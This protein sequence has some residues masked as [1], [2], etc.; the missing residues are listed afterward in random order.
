MS[1]ASGCFL[2][3]GFLV[4]GGGGGA[5]VGGVVG[6]TSWFPRQIQRVPVNSGPNADR[7]W[8]DLSGTPGCF[9]VVGVVVVVGGGGCGVVGGIVECYQSIPTS[10]PATSG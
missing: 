7:I 3:V 9:V 8:S 6:L 10:I 5:G 1:G 4:A 2:V